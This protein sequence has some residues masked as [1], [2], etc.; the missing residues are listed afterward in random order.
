MYELEL[1]EDQR[2]QEAK[3]R[4]ENDISEDEH[5]RQHT[6]GPSSGGAKHEG[7][8]LSEFF[9]HC[10][11]IKRYAVTVDNAVVCMYMFLYIYNVCMCVYMNT[12]ILSVH[13]KY[14]F[15]H[16]F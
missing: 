1:E 8:Y 10:S 6:P 15:Y 11:Y 7:M 12:H 14:I 2:R 13:F 3:E 16:Y 5:K 9:R 4:K